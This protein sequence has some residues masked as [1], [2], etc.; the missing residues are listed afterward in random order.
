MRMWMVN[1]KK[2]CMNHLNGEHRELHALVGMIN[3]GTS[4]KGYIDGG[5]I[6]VH[7]I[8]QR[9]NELA[10]ELLRRELI[11]NPNPTT[12]P[13]HKSPLPFFTYRKEGSI[14]IDDNIE[15]LIKRCSKCKENLQ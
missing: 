10:S 5:L 7:S 14:D 6:E 12:K 4:L 11:R 13:F 8:R 2:L 9:H 1:P 3:K 15:E